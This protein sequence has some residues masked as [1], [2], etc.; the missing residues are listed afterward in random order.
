MEMEVCN[1]GC[2]GSES[3]ARHI[4]AFTLVVCVLENR[5]EFFVG[6]QNLPTLR[7][8]CLAISKLIKL[9]LMHTVHAA[10]KGVN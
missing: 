8:L 5:F 6:A 3:P 7:L 9:C 10:P 2:G 1:H 4:T